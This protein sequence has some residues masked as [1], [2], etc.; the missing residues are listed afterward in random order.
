MANLRYADL[1]DFC[2]RSGLKKNRIAARLGVSPQ[3]FSSLLNPTVYRPRVTGDL[4][5]KIAGLLRQPVSYVK[6]L[7]RPKAA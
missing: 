2:E 6:K 1:P 7:Y 4:A 3:F 5:V